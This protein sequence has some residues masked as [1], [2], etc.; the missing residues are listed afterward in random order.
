VH[1][2][3][4]IFRVSADGSRVQCA[5]S[6]TFQLAEYAAQFR[7]LAQPGQYVILNRNTGHEITLN[8]KSSARGM[9]RSTGWDAQRRIAYWRSAERAE[10]DNFLILLL[11]KGGN[12]NRNA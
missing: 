12:P 3:F 2:D 4:A 7:A 8:L 11:S 10:S 5:E 1:R 9:A 6:E